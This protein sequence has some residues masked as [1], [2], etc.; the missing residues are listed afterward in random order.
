MKVAALKL[1]LHGQTV[2]YVAGYRDVLRNVL[3]LDPA[4]IENPGRHTLTLSFT[5]QADFKRAASIFPTSSRQQMHPLL[6]NLLPEGALREILAQRLKIHPMNEFPL[7]AH[8]GADLPGALVVQPVTAHDIPDYAFGDWGKLDRIAVDVEPGKTHFSLAGVQMKFSMHQKDGRYI[9]SEAADAPGD[10]IIKTPSTTHEHVPV[11]EFT[12]M[13]L[14]GAIGVDIPEIRLVELSKLDRLPEI[15]LPDEPFAYG[16]RRFDRTAQGRV[17]TEDFAQVTFTYAAQKYDKHSYED[18]GRLL[19]RY[20]Y[21]GQKDAV[22]MA[23][24]LLANI[25]LANGDA[26]K[27]NWSLIYP[28]GINAHLAPAY[29]I[30]ST[31]MYMRD[32]LDFALSLGG[33]KQWYAVTFEHFERWAKKADISYSPVKYNLGLAMK[34]AR[35]LWP[36]MLAESPMRET[37]KEALRQH[38]RALQPDFRIAS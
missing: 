27:K 32:E 30:V 2:G 20:A 11:N 38:W 17:H 14:A 25:L 15:K 37:H 34:R 26:H 7:L 9:L 19:Y 23:I 6:S 28:D 21:A 1:S 10:W 12:S 35:E 16:I 8:L 31:K 36:R 4:F 33:T 3:S 29:D 18:I 24:R 5:P 22:Q 13:Q